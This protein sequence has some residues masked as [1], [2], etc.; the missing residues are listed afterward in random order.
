MERIGDKPNLTIRRDLHPLC[1]EQ[2][3]DRF[4]RIIVEGYQRQLKQKT[5]TEEIF[6]RNLTSWYASAAESE[7]P[8]DLEKVRRALNGGGILEQIEGKYKELQEQAS[9]AV[10]IRLERL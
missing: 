1:E 7:E 2:P 9:I 6:F 3:E 4:A 10:Q 8:R 5:I